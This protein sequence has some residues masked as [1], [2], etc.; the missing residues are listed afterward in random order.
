MK[1]L[2]R[3]REAKTK[4][5]RQQ[6]ELEITKAWDTANIKTDKFNNMIQ[7]IGSDTISAIATSG[8]EMLVCIVCVCGVCVRVRV[9]ARVHAYMQVCIL[10]TV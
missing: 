10:V 8:P 4:Y 6:N 5:V 7:A 1:R 9:C 2:S 3:A